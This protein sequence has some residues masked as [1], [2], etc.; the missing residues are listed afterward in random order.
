MNQAVYTGELDVRVS[1][2]ERTRTT[3]VTGEKSVV[4]T[5]F[6]TVWAKVEDVSGTEE[7]DGK[8]IAL[9]VRKYILNYDPALVLKNITDLYISDNSN[10][11]NIHSVSFIGRK[12]YIQLKCSKRE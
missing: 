6:N 9:N 3:S 4:E 8:V 7:A 1:I 5:L 10:L 12:E 11:Y 2:I